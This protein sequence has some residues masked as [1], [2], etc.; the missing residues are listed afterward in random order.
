[1]S[2][3]A[4]V[5]VSSLKTPST[6]LSIV[7]NLYAKE[8]K[9]DFLKTEIQYLG[10]VISSQGVHMD[11]FKVDAIVHWPYPTNLEELQ[12][13]LGL[14]SFYRK[15]VRDYATIDVPMTDQLKGKG[16]T[17][18]WGEEQQRSFEKLKVA[19]ASAP[20]LAIMDP[21]KPFVVETDASDR[22]IGA[23]WLQDGR[24]IAFESKKSDKA[25]QNYYVYE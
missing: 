5:V 20:N 22:A 6:F 14:T 19:L 8:S 15:Y 12:I 4:A 13:F 7:H 10:H 23:V 11:M 16:K 25:Q 1:M 17:F 2:L 9:C 21:T 3:K 24:P 18:T